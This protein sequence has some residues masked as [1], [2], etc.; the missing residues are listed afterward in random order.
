MFFKHIILEGS[1]LDF[2][3]PGPRFWRVL[4]TIFR[5]FRS[6]WNSFPRN[7]R[8]INKTPRTPRTP[9]KTRPRSQIRQEWVGGGAPPPGGF[10]PPPTEGV[11]S[12]LDSHPH[13]FQ[14]H[15]DQSQRANLK[16]QALYAR[17]G[18]CSPLF[19][20]PQEAGDNRNPPLNLRLLR[21]WGLLGR[22]FALPERA[23]KMTSKK[24]RK[25]CENR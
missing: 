15:P 14:I 9:A 1:R 7:G 13:S 8:F 6:F 21:F 18:S 11:R 25:K 2:G 20:S 24:H 19:F 12:V 10:N 22:F 23:S 17:L 5:S 4:G 3:G 16:G